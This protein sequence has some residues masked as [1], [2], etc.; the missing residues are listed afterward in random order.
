MWLIEIDYF[1]DWHSLY[2][3]NTSSI[4]IFRKRWIVLLYYEKKEREKKKNQ[5]H[6]LFQHL[7]VKVCYHAMIYNPSFCVLNQNQT[8]MYHLR[9]PCQ[10]K[11]FLSAVCFFPEWSFYVS[12]F[13]LQGLV[14]QRKQ[15][16]GWYIGT[17]CSLA[18]VKI[19]WNPGKL[20]SLHQ[21][22]STVWVN[23]IYRCWCNNHT[24]FVLCPHF[25][26]TT[27]MDSKAEHTPPEFRA[28]HSHHQSCAYV[29]CCLATHPHTFPCASSSQPVSY[30]FLVC[31]KTLSEKA[32]EHIVQTYNKKQWKHADREWRRFVKLAWLFPLTEWI[33]NIFT[34]PNYAKCIGWYSNLFPSWYLFLTEMSCCSTEL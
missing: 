25:V 34:D 18:R 7:S 20:N 4:L 19:K 11:P 14:W 10:I 15:K 8:A 29:P 9:K 1:T 16:M 17:L 5:F 23:V 22:I 33:Q 2:T 31:S 3:Y 12:A 32:L 26:L 13:C 21:T 27:S 6:C 30:S 24:D 28:L